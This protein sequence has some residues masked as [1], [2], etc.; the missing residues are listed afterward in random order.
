MKKILFFPMIATLSCDNVYS[1]AKKPTVKRTST[2]ISAK[3][4]AQQSSVIDGCSFFRLKAL[5][6]IIFCKFA[7]YYIEFTPT[8][9]NHYLN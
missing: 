1:Q 2:N 4:K 5:D 8:N 3:Q 6:S 7:P 9:Q